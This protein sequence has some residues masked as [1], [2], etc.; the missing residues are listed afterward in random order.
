MKKS[1]YRASLGFF[2][3]YAK[4]SSLLRWC[5]DATYNVKNAHGARFMEIDPLHPE[6][7]PGQHLLRLDSLYKDGDVICPGMMIDVGNREAFRN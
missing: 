4:S 6:P 2:Y 5:V 3:G 7:S 1:E